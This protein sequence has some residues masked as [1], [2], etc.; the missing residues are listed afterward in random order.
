MQSALLMVP[1]IPMVKWVWGHLGPES[2]RGLPSRG[3]EH[4]MDGRRG[5]V[6]PERKEPKPWASCGDREDARG[7]GL[8]YIPGGDL[9]LEKAASPLGS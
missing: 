7:G 8:G 1:H 4:T 3:A 6:P 5:A 9:S 2:T